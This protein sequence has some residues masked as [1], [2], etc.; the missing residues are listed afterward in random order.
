MFSTT[1]PWRRRGRLAMR[2]PLLLIAFS[3]GPAARAQAS[4]AA[5]SFD[6]A[7]VEQVLQGLNRGRSV[8][9]VAVSPD[10]KHIAWIEGMRDGGEIRVAP[11]NDLSKGDLTKAERVSAATRPDQRCRENDLTWAPDS[12]A[13]A[14]FSDCADPGEQVDLYLWTTPGRITSHIQRLRA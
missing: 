5:S 13:L 10:G 3:A 12:K 6:R 7:H 9:Q 1:L 14:F 4:Q 11:V 8:G 2:F